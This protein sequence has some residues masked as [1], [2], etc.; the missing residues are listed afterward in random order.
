MTPTLR[1]L[2]W[3]S[4]LGVF[5]PAR[6]LLPSPLLAPLPALLMALLPAGSAASHTS[7]PSHLTA[8]PPGFYGHWKNAGSYLA[9]TPQL[10]WLCL[11]C[12]LTSVRPPS[13]LALSNAS[14]CAAAAE[15]RLAPRDG[16]RRR[17]YLSPLGLLMSVDGASFD[18]AILN[19]QPAPTSVAIRLKPTPPGSTHAMLTLRADGGA[20]ERRVRLRCS[21][22][23]GFE[24]SVF[25]GDAPDVWRIRLGSAEGATLEMSAE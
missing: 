18:Q 9:C 25:A 4:E 12:E 3:V 8:P 17:L 24:P 11:H 6:V 2:A 19:L 13:A 14:A 10:G 7:T 23:C 15:M 21:A 22:P 20:P 16:F 5:D 1:T